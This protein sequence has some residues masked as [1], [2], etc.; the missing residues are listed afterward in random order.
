MK[1]GVAFLPPPG[2][3]AGFVLT[4]RQGQIVAALAEGHTTDSVAEGLGL[5]TETIRTH[6][7]RILAKTNSR[8][9]GQVLY[10]YGAGQLRIEGVDA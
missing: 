1:T 7:K 5:S 4:T 2:D 8:T 3:Q 6:M 10:K 9:R